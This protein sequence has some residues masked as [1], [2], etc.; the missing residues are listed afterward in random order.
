VTL[1]G[2][3]LAN[4]KTLKAKKVPKNIFDFFLQISTFQVSTSKH[5]E[6]ENS[7]GSILNIERMIFIGHLNF[8]VKLGPTMNRFFALTTSTGEAKRIPIY[9]SNFSI[10]EK[11]QK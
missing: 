10:R 9:Y 1:I 4:F 7:W 3:E 11:K 8:I 6:R 2:T 5:S